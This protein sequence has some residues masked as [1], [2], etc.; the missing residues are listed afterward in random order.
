MMK[1]S[2]TYLISSRKDYMQP[3]NPLQSRFVFLSFSLTT[4]PNPRRQL[5]LTLTVIILFYN[6]AF[7][8]RDEWV[9]EAC[10]VKM[11]GTV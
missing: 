3:R 4:T 9:N 5:Y 6:V 2:R 11:E 7:D 8:F 1:S 10:K